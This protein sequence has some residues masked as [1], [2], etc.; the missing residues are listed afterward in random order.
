MAKFKVVAD[1]VGVR[2]GPA[3]VRFSAH[4]G[5]VVDEATITAAGLKVES[6]L[7]AGAIE[8]APAG[9]AVTCVADAKKATATVSGGGAVA[10]P[11]KAEDK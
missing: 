5:D 2:G 4:A 8:P 11:V 7:G 10:S 9:A 6:L 1:E 3:E